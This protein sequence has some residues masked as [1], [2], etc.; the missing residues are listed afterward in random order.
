[1]LTV[2]LFHENDVRATEQEVEGSARETY[3]TSPGGAN[4]H[5]TEFRHV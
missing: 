3:F 1:M 4:H 5:H 2:H